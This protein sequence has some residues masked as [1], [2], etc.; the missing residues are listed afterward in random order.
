MSHTLISLVAM[1]SVVLFGR[2]ACASEAELTQQTLFVRGEGGY[3]IYR[4]PSLIVTPKGSLLVFCEGREAGDSSDID[5]LLRRSDDGGSTW[6]EKQVVWDEGKNVCGNPCPVV[7]E[8]TGI[9][10]L[11]MTW[12][13]SKDRDQQLHEG[14]GKD[15]R[16]PYVC[17]SKDDGYTW[18]EPVEITESTKR[19]DWLWYATGPGIGIQLRHEP[20]KGRLV[21]P[22][23][24]TD[25]E[26]FGAHVVYSDDHG[27]TW[28]I[29]GAVPGGANECQ[30]V[31]LA[32][33]TLML[34]M[35]MQKNGDGKRGVATSRDGGMTWSELTLDSTL[36]DPICQ[37]SFIRYSLEERGDKNRLLFSN[38]AAP[39]LPGKEKRERAMMTIRLSE[40][41]GETWHVSRLLNE[42]FSAYSCLAALPDGSIGCLYEAG[43]VP[44]GEIVFA[45][46]TLQWLEAK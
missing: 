33:G 31:E 14:T 35:R 38:P 43:S 21:I 15:T 7:D 39:P 22:C 20:H 30:V 16:R 41:E 4:I 37:A 17:H 46:F 24:Y 5:M 34:N 10:W 2:F 11:L 28:K 9:I 25:K 27:E 12:N 1:I 32:D 6:S 13:N 45:R 40:D 18:S 36:V 26:G 19:P 29:G 3:N 23:D 8:D 42:G 44:Y